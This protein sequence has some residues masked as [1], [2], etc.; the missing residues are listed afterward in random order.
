MKNPYQA[1]S[2]A[3][4]TVPKT[5]QVV[6]LYDEIIRQLNH[7]REAMANQQV[8][9][10]FNKLVRASEILAG[11]QMSLDFD[12]G[13]QTASMLF[14]MYAYLES[15]VAKLHRTGDI[16]ACDALIQE[17]KQWRELW[18]R[19]DVGAV[20]DDGVVTPSAPVDQGD[21]SEEATAYAVRADEDQATQPVSAQ[22]AG[23][24]PPTTSHA[25]APLSLGMAGQ[26]FGFS[27]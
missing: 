6:M 16:V 27:A 26:T 2:S 20:G 11:L 1:Y 13:R 15:Q 19:I 25:T 12:Q 9:L 8:E 3:N 10:R 4:Y 22:G 17:I 7:A 18:H 21:A 24:Q 14:D 5:R 23:S